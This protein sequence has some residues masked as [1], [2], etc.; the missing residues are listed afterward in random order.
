MPALTG[1][2]HMGPVK[3]V[4][5]L[6]STIALP[7]GDVPEWIH[8]LP[9]GPVRTVD[10]RGPYRV[11][12]V[13]ALMAA[14]MAGGKLVL[15][16]NHATDRAAPLGQS[17]P[18]RGWI[19]DL[20]QRADG[21]WGKVQWTAEGR[22]I[23]PGYRGISPAIL[24]DK[25]GTISAI[26]RASLVNVPNLVGLAALHA[27]ENTQMDF[28]KMLL[29]VLGLDSDADEAAIAAAIAKM[30][31]APKADA[32]V[33]TALQSALAPIAAAAGVPAG[34]DAA[35]VLAGV[36]RLK[37]SAS[38]DATIVA[39]QSELTDM[40]G[41]F[42]S[43]LDATTRKDATAFVDGAIAAGRVGVKPMRDR[44]IAMH[45]ADPAGTAALV[46]ALP[47]ITGGATLRGDPKDIAQ[48]GIGAEDAQVIALMGL[49]RAEYAKTLGADKQE[50]L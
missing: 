27:Q 19:I 50:T 29:E 23:V 31:D 24:H 47:A 18:A 26:V 48:D 7:D 34:A 46:G 11:G 38:D 22:A 49:D 6:C 42:A 13:A 35:V 5:A 39:L 43:H 4:L 28:R 3:D 32:V 2:G 15:D 14:S 44:Y 30:K 8:L 10:G 1:S 41:K 37:A 40:A 17:A 45:M 9:A 20:Q 12:D 16:E 21:I 33:A 36:Q 25:S